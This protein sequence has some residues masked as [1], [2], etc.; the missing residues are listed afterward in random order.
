M[1]KITFCIPSKDNL[2]YLK[3]SVKSIRENSIIQHDIIVYVDG[4]NDKT[5]HWLDSEGITYLK[6]ESDSPKG[7]AYAY[8]RCIEAATTPIVCMF[9]ADMYMGKGFDI[10][11]LKYIKP[12]TVVS[13]TRIEP[14]LHPKGLEKIVK[15][16]GMYP[17][18]FTKEKFNDFVDKTISE[19]K[20][21]ITKGIFAPWAIYKEDITSIGMHD[22]KYHSY[23]EDS[24]IFNRFILNGYEIIQTWEGLVY[25]LTCRG[26]QFQDGI[27]Q[28]TTNEAFHK[29]KKYALNLYINKWGT[30]V[31]NNEY[32]YPILSPVYK[33]SINISNSSTQLEEILKPWFNEGKDIIVNVD[34]KTFTQQD[35]IYIQQLNSIIKDSGEVGEFELG[36]LKIKINSLDEY[37]NTLIKL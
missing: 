11:I 30:F 18:D 2:R 31:Q 28:V 6:N 12:S 17:E 32:Q 8:N 24:D 26:G 37:Q 15:D 9:H 14:P 10:A 5:S 16:F 21:I 4:D 25:H 22:E 20:D 35:F 27:E 7:I 23:H 36:N 3:N 33:K 34:G 13:G 19:N 1:N 29:M